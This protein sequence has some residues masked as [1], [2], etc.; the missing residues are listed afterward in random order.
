[1][2][3]FRS[4]PLTT[5]LQRYFM[6]PKTTYSIRWHD[7]KWVK[8]G[9]F[10][11]L[12]VTGAWKTVDATKSSYGEKPHNVEFHLTTDDFDPFSEKRNPYIM[13]LLVL[14]PF[15]VLPE[16]CLKDTNYLLSMLIPRPNAPKN[17]IDIYLQLLVD[18]INKL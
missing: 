3:V 10:K 1:M 2:K 17:D 6:S 7:E 13:W 5:R 16:M 15:I 8:D 11:H 4:F 18:E 14:I 9:V 12:A